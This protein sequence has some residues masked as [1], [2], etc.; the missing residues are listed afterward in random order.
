[1]IFGCFGI[2]YPGM[3]KWL[4]TIGRVVIYVAL[5]A[6]AISLSKFFSETTII[7]VAMIAICLVLETKIQTLSERVDALELEASDLQNDTERAI[8]LGYQALDGISGI[9]RDDEQI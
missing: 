2:T 9:K 8:D 3:R 4:A 1:M 5:F 7:W 6:A